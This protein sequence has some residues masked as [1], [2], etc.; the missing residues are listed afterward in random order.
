MAELFGRHHVELVR[1][2]VL[3][4]GD[5]PTA[6]DVVQDVFARMQAGRAGP[7]GLAR[8]CRISGPAC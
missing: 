3:V 6:E 2:G 1:L 7:A 4:V 5:Q 8:S